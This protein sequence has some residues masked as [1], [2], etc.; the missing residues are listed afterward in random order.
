MTA[1]AFKSFAHLHQFE[2]GEGGTVMIDEI[3]FQS[4]LGLIG[5]LVDYVFMAGYLRRLLEARCQAIK[6]EAESGV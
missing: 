3:T 1:G 2:S 6:R 4:P 5:A